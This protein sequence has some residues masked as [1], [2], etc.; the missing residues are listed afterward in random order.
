MAQT[1][2]IVNLLRLFNPML[3]PVLLPIIGVYRKFRNS[4]L[5]VNMRGDFRVIF[6][7]NWSQVPIIGSFVM[8]NGFD[9]D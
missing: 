5:G 6:R 4:F 3:T 8:F 1:H 2:Y 9:I 7:L